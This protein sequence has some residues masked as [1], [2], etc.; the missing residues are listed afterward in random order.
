MKTKNGL[1]LRIKYIYIYIDQYVLTLYFKIRSQ[2][3]RI[4]AMAVTK[5][6]V[7]GDETR[8]P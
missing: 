7:A 4:K 8:T 5:T 1:Y 6:V 2:G 3:V